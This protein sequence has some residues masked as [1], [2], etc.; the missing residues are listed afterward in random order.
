V[1]LS[2]HEVRSRKDD[3]SL[4]L[5]RLVMIVGASP[6]LFSEPCFSYESPTPSTVSGILTSHQG[7]RDWW[8]I[9]LDQ[10]ICTLKDTSDPFGLA[11]S[12]VKELQI[13]LARSDDYSRYRNLLGQ[14]ITASGKFFPRA[15]AYHQTNVL[16]MADRISFANEKEVSALPPA[17]GKSLNTH[18]PELAFYFASATILPA[19]ASRVIKQAWDNDPDSFLPESDRYIEHL[20]NGPMDIMWV[21]CRTGYT[22]SDPKSSTGSSI[23]R[24]D[25]GNPRN[26]YWGVAVSDSQRTNITVR[27]GK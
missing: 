18:L 4:R 14:R 8:G 24:M 1:R 13:V 3:N 7:L 11:Y 21:K 17:K 27:C 6:L 12:G 16:I 20:F 23:F 2:G 10:A 19:P 22:I 5:F 26:Q 15:T 9:T 25:A